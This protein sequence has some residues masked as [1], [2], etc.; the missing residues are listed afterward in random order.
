MTTKKYRNIFGKPI[1][2]NLKCRVAEEEFEEEVTQ[3]LKNLV[4]AKYLEVVKW[5]KIMR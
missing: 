2:V 3:E 1:N 5:I 4:L